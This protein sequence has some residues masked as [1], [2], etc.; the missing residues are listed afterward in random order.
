M[1]L[2]ILRV[3]SGISDNNLS[4]FNITQYSANVFV[5][6]LQTPLILISNNFSHKTPT[7]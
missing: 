1:L 6:S 7:L 2:F 4:A 3:S 5:Y